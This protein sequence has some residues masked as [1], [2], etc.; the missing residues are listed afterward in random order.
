VNAL[1]RSSRPAYQQIADEL[2]EEIECEAFGDEGRLPTEAELVERY[3]VTRGTVREA[4]KVLVAEGLVVSD[5]PRG[6]F[7]RRRKRMV[8]RPQDELRVTD[9]LAP[10]MD[11]F[12]TMLAA[13][14]RT[15]TQTID[16]AIVVPP[17]EIATRLRLG[18]GETAAV[19]RRVRSIDGEP[20]NIN[21]SYYPLDLVQGS[22]I[23]LPHD[24]ARGANRVLAELG[25]RQVGLRHH[26]ISR[27]PTQTEIHR[28]DL[29]PGTTVIV[30]YLTGFDEAGRPV[31]AVENVLPG[32]RHIVLAED[33]DVPADTTDE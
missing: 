22:E 24:I 5:R 23:V 19:R 33:G 12:H 11:R 31:R 18:V 2:R 14:G 16:V 1:H 27:M 4:L 29:T 32:D 8:Y 17:A 3:S 25:H 21:D 7:V 13:E 10:A 9:G 15:A 28:L 20:F 30:H 6:Y 26:F